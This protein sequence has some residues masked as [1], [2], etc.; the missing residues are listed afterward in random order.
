MFTV[1]SSLCVSTIV[2]A[3][4]DLYQFPISIFGAGHFPVAPFFEDFLLVV[5]IG[6]LNVVQADSAVMELTL[7]IR[8]FR[9]SIG[10][11]LG[12]RSGQS[13]VSQF[14]AQ[15]AKRTGAATSWVTAA[16]SALL[17]PINN[18][19]PMQDFLFSQ[20]SSRFGAWRLEIFLTFSSVADRE[21]D[22]WETGLLLVTLLRLLELRLS[23]GKPLFLNRGTDMS[24]VISG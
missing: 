24:P 8:S 14:F 1:F 12:S 2:G 10:L 13:L 18:E 20:K 21:E 9:I 17:E 4:D 3:W 15:L 7:V 23:K 5:G 6:A 16:V 11:E 19:K 22:F